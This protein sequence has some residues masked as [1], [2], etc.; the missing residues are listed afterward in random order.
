MQAPSAFLALSSDIPKTHAGLIAALGKHLVQPGLIATD[1]G[2]AFNQV[3]R[4]RQLADYAKEPI[5]LPDAAW[6]VEQAERF[7]DAVRRRFATR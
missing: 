4:L 6:A 1:L 2:R 5:G 7:V 3:Q